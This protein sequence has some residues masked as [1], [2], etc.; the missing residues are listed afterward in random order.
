MN[1]SNDCSGFDVLKR[2]HTSRS[3][4]W[5]SF[6]E[7]G[8]A[9][10]HGECSLVSVSDE[11]VTFEFGASARGSLTIALTDVDLDVLSAP[12]RPDPLFVSWLV[13][14]FKLLGAWGI[15]CRVSEFNPDLFPSVR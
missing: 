7:P 13:F 15:G 11:S 5:I 2:W 3:R 4:L 8:A 6:W 14:T 10:V 9:A 1:S 12:P